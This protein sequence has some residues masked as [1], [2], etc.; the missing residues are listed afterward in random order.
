MSKTLWFGLVLGLI[1]NVAGALPPAEYP[2]FDSLTYK[3]SEAAAAAWI[4]HQ[5]TAPPSVLQ[6]DSRPVLRLPCNFSGTDHPRAVWDLPLNRD[7]STARGIQFRF[8]CPDPLP[9]GSFT[10]YLRSGNGWYTGDFLHTAEPVPDAPGWHTVSLD[11]TSA[12]IE[13][14]PRGWAHVDRLRI[15]AWRGADIDTEIHLADLGIV[16]GDGDMLLVLNEPA[17][18]Q[19]LSAYVRNVDQA[20]N[21]MGLFP[22]LV[23]ER[24]VTADRLRDTRVVILPYNPDLPP[25]AVEALASHMDR[26]GKLVAFFALPESLARRGGI[27]LGGVRG[28]AER[29]DFSVIQAVG[30]GLRG[31]PDRIAQA[32]WNIRMAEPV[33]PSGRVAA[34]WRDRDGHPKGAAVVVTD[35]AAFMSHILLNDDLDRK[36]QLTL[37]MVGHVFSTAF[38]QAAEH[39][40]AAIG[41]IGAYRNLDELRRAVE[42][43]HTP[44][45]V[46]RLRT[47]ESLRTQ[48][49][50]HL[51][52][53]A[54]ERAV[55]IAVESRQRAREAYA[56]LQQP[57]QGEFRGF[58]CHDAYGIPGRSWDETAEALARNGFTAVLPN[59]SWGG[60][61]FYD[62]D[63]LPVASDVERYG[64]AL[65]ECIAAARRHG[66]EVHAWKVN[67]NMGSKAPSGFRTRMKQE[68]RTQVHFNG[69]AHDAWLCPTDP[70][71]QRLEIDAMVEM[72]TRY[73]VDGI[74]FDYIRF[75]GSDYCFC[76]GCRRRFEEYLGRS[77]SGW[78]GAVRTDSDVEKAWLEFRRKAISHVVEA[79]RKEVRAVRPECKISAAVFPDWP[80]DRDRIGQ[81]WGAWARAGHLDFINPMNYTPFTPLFEGMA[82]RQQEW[83]GEAPVY[84]G[85]GLTTWTDPAD[86]G[87]LAAQIKVARERNA[88]GFTLFNL[89]A[90]ALDDVAPLLR[91]GLTRPMAE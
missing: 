7:L 36:R 63:V 3:D 6:T 61:A 44:G 43:A 40:I 17:P 74:H 66:I 80:R 52:Q 30:D 35:Q 2:V 62:S 9:V 14:T 39:Q 26:G 37:A 48:A 59:V 23:N 18:G 79:V 22:A 78:P 27:R 84:P 11:K 34:E 50:E 49:R 71:N 67:W 73:P 32:S 4:T 46:E 83:A 41:A 86:F 81:D 76:A 68:G 89:T 8:R 60:V 31:L 91:L 53:N 69:T 29:G 47:A 38:E 85:I 90:G 19:P 58:W 70:R 15:A 56:A 5:G 51:I 10:A 64:N 42:Q 21:A 12:R 87:R 1:A 57:R 65:E 75:P 13:G 72:A 24:D 82:A 55:G 77:V 28:E 33:H 88:P 45:A 54:P 20:L 25:R 16:S